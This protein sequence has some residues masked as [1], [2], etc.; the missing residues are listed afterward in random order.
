MAYLGLVPSAQSH[1]TALLAN[2]SLGVAKV[3]HPFHHLHGQIFEVLKVRRLGGQD[4][5]SLRHPDFGS[6]AMP[7]DWTD[8]APP[9]AEPPPGAAPLLVDA[10]ALLRLAEFA[11]TL[12]L[13]KGVDA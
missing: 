5:L 4:S 11:A 2:R 7:R 10:F 9:G 12:K 6:F 3:T 1:Q 13:A 8:W